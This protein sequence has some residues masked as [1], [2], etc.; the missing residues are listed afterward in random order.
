LMRRALVGIVPSEILDRRRKAYVSRAAFSALARE[1]AWFDE[2]SINMIA[3]S[4]GIVSAPCFAQI[5]QRARKGQEVPIVT[6][7]RTI[8]L[9]IWLREMR[10]R[11]QLKN[12]CV[13]IPHRHD[14]AE[15]DQGQSQ[16]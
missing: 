1:R 9:E 13:E 2:L 10:R 4:L 16:R 11:N 15:R 7:L 14:Q 8:E 6:L 3:S 12:T 5:V